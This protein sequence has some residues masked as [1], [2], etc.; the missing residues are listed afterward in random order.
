MKHGAY[1]P[2][3]SAGLKASLGGDG[4]ITAWRTDYVQFADAESETVFPYD[5]PAVARHHYKYI[6]HQVDAYW[7]SV[8]STQHGFY[9]ESFMD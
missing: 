1:R 6:S 7:R 3:S 9:N 5:V 4:K 2:Q 8:N